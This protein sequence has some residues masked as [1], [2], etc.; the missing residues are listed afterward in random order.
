MPGRVNGF[1]LAYTSAGAVVLWSG[2]KGW[3]IS[4][5]FKALLGGI[6]PSS[7]TEPIDTS[8]VETTSEAPAA[9]GATGSAIADDALKYEGHGYV[10][11]GPSNP[12]GG[13]DC[14]SFVSYV[15]GHDLGLKIPGGTW[16]SVTDNGKS[17]GPVS[18]QYMLYGTG[19]KAAQ[20]QAGDIIAS[21]D[22]VG[23]IVTNNGGSGTMISAQDEQLGTG[24]SNWPAGFP[25]GIPVYRRVAA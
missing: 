11:G 15:L 14:S 25:G 13:W 24:V 18:A 5:T 9:G 1:S 12:T 16:A 23:F 20:A 19:I 22:H 2:I 17:H 3:S 7:S 4:S 8:T 6:T 21:V 10:F